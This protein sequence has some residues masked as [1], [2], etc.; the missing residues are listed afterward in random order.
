MYKKAFLAV[1]ILGLIVLAGLEIP[2][3][4]Q[5]GGTPSVLAVRQQADLVH[6]ITAKR[7]DTLLPRMM[8]ETGLDMW[9]ISC[10][11][12]NL[13]PIFE[14][15][16]PLGNWNPITQ[17]LVFYDQGP[18]KGI[19]RLNVSRTDTQGLFKNAWDAA[20][21]DTK[22]GESQWDALGRVVRERDPKRIGLNEG[23]VQ[24]VA[25]GLTSVLKKRI[26]EAVG[27]KYA[28]RLQSAEPLVTLWAETLLDEEVEL[29]E[30]AAAL[31]RSIIADMFSSKV[32][33]VGQ[34]T[35]DDLRWYYWQRV[36]DLGLKVSFSPFVSIRGRSPKDVEKWGKDDKVIRPG[37]LLHCDVGLKYMRYNSDHQEMAYVLRPSETD[38]PETF[39]KLMAEANRLQDVYCGEF[40]AGLT[41][42]ELLG[43]IL[44]KARE[45]GIPGPRVYSHS[46]GY[47]LHEPGPLIGLPWEQVNN[48][49]RGDVKLVPMSTFVAEMSVTG[50]VPEWGVD[51]RVP[52]EQDILFDGERAFFLAGRQ[53]SFHLIK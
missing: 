32:V 31:S 5:H 43:N 26:A 41:G 45:L 35:S 25:G 49:G 2:A 24:W 17:I 13:D 53:T 50:P 42:N 39:K 36:A 29:M 19:E 27:P 33:T 21:W 6:K 52:L 8:R 28:A 7:L 44:K 15:M 3:A 48:V 4:A 23:E 16:V 14:T 38:A 12:D 40:K 37:D 1:V 47:F 9:I 51:F 20:A 22:K 18:A 34:T 46:L 11:E 30:R 10:N